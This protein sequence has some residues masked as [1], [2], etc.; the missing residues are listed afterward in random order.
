MR[1][2]FEDEE[3]NKTGQLDL[4]DYGYERRA[5]ESTEHPSSSTLATA[6]RARIIASGFGHRGQ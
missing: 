3:G 6:T 5:P 1:R 2:I 4:R